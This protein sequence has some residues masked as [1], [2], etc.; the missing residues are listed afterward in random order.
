[1][2]VGKCVSR[3]ASGVAVQSLIRSDSGFKS[4]HFR[5][6][7][8]A[9]GVGRLYWTV[10][11][12]AFLLHLWLRHLALSNTAATINITNSE[13]CKI[14][15][16]SRHFYFIALRNYW[17]YSEQRHFKNRQVHNYKRWRIND[18]QK[19]IAAAELGK[20]SAVLLHWREHAVE[21]HDCFWFGA[22][23]LISVKEED[24]ML[25]HRI[26]K[27]DDGFLKIRH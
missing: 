19:S 2:E 14:R 24:I 27:M 25:M 3:K 16:F 15:D 5:K 9:A 20:I 4:T 6:L 23:L 7:T 12:A 22:G 21:I 26:T 11:K 13:L 1:M 10:T 8:H 18:A 17:K